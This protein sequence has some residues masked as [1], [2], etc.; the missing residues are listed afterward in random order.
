MCIRDRWDITQFDPDFKLYVD[1][2]IDQIKNKFFKRQKNEDEISYSKRTSID[3]SS[4]YFNK[5]KQNIIDSIAGTKRR[6]QTKISM[7]ND[8]SV[9]VKVDPFREVIVN[10]A[11]NLNPS[12]LGVEELNYNIN[13]INSFDISNVLLV[14]K[15]NGQSY[16]YNPERDKRI[17]REEQES[18]LLAQEISRQEVVLKNNL[19]EIVASLKEDGIINEVDLSVDSRLVKA[20][21]YTHLTLPTKA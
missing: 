1:K 7:V 9:K 2:R 5:S 13:E 12:L 11:S 18:I 14:N 21:S 3:I 6:G 20:V 19:T 10:V 16:G 17:I 8:G 15:E 4:N